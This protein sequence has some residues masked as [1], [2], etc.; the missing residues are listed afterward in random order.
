MWRQ[1]LDSTADLVLG[2][3]CAGC[4]RA[5]LG[6][7]A[8]CRKRVCGTQPFAVSG[9][10]QGSCL[11]VAAGSYRAE[12]RRLLLAAKERQAL[13]LLPLLGERLAAAAAAVVLAN[14]TPG[15]IL[16]VPIPTTRAHIA[17]RGLDLPRALARI[18]ARD[19]RAAGVPV[20]VW[21]GL[22]LRQRRADQK[23]LG[24]AQRLENLVGA[25]GAR[26]GAETGQALVVDDIV[27]TGSTLIEA[28]RALAAV[29][30]PV[31]GSAVVAATPRR[32]G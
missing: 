23:E 20:R 9:L 25:F 13:G 6:P 30:M 29:E 8:A 21:P 28:A 4:G 24:R 7:C 10:S 3:Q 2:A 12:L 17:A 15:S 32:Q 26:P 5:G 18:A 14:Q 27:T 31:V 11:V 22:R 1:I 16:L 19:L